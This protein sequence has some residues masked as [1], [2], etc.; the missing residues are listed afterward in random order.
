[1]GGAAGVLVGLA[2]ELVREAYQHL[3]SKVKTLT[4]GEQ[5]ET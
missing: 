5:V 2:A 1:M 4:V 3:R